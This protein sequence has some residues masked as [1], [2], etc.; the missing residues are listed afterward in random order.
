MK[1]E[2]LIHIL[3]EYILHKPDRPFEKLQD[4]VDEIEAT[5]E[6]VK[7]AI[8]RATDVLAKAGRAGPNLQ[9]KKTVFPLENAKLNFFSSTAN[10]IRDISNIE[11][12]KFANLPS[13]VRFSPFFVGSFVI[14]MI[15][16]I[17]LSRLDT[18]KLYSPTPENNKQSIIYNSLLEP[19][20]VFASEE[21]ID[22]KRVFSFPTSSISLKF[23]GELKNEVF[24]FFPYWMLDAQDQI[25]LDGYTSISLFGLNADSNGNIVTQTSNSEQDPGWAMWIDNRTDELIARAKRKRIKVFITIKSFNNDDIERLVTSDDSQKRLIANILQLINMKSLNGVNLDF[26]YVGKAPQ[27]VV[28]GMTRL[29]AN[30]N[31][32]L[33]RQMPNAQLTVDTYIKSAAEVD[34]FDVQV[35]QDNVDALIIMGYDI[36]TPLGAPGPIA[37]LEGGDGI[38]GYMQSYIERVTPDKLILAVPQYGYDWIIDPDKQNSSDSSETVEESGEKAAILSYAEIAAESSKYKI[39]WDDASQTPYYQYMDRENQKAHEVHFENTRSLGLKYD[40]IKNKK[41]KGV[42]VW[43]IGYDGLNQE[44]QQL[45]LEKF[46]N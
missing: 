40:Y 35:L 28:F 4:F 18:T 45:I 8:L 26:E 36:H 29:V 38:M 14:I 41:L 2:L 34:F 43:A 27:P 39:L 31:S 33:K 3:Q 17:N 37:P 6:E 46:T 9:I 25:T 22:A 30:L 23:S 16:F 42:G 20:A 15:I 44:M 10:Q 5:P 19:K 21:K 32:E 24:G 13:L 11:F 7:E 12:G 1:R